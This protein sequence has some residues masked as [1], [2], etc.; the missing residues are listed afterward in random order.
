MIRPESLLAYEELDLTG[1]RNESGNIDDITDS[2]TSKP[3]DYSMCRD[4]SSDE[5]RKHGFLILINSI[6][7]NYGVAMSYDPNQDA[8]YPIRTAFRGFPESSME[9]MYQGLALWMKTHADELCAEAFEGDGCLSG[10]CGAGRGGRGPRRVC[11]RRR[12]RR[13]RGSR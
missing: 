2:Q 13:R 10:L 6:L 9:K 3:S 12:A 1:F 4:L 7:H 5:F 11:R 8:F